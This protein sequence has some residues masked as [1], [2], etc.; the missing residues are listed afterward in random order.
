MQITDFHATYYAYLLTRHT[1]EN[2][3]AALAAT[4]QDSRVDLNPHQIEA[5]LFALRSPYSRGIIE[6]DEVGLGK[7]IVAGIVLAQ[8][9]A[10]EKR[11]I[12]IIVPAN[13]RR[14][15]QIEL[16]EKFYLS[17][18]IM[19]GEVFK[20][21]EKSQSNPFLL[22]DIII[23]SYN[24]AHAKSNF[25]RAVDWDIC[26]IDEAHKLRNVYKPDNVIARS[27]KEALRDCYKIMLTATP[28]QNSLMEL[29]GL[30]SFIDDYTFGD[31]DSFKSQFANMRA[32]NQREF[33][34]LSDRMKSLCTRTLRRQVV[35]Y[36]KYTERLPITQ[37]FSPT[38]AEQELYDK[39]SA[40]LQ[41]SDMK[42]RSLISIILWKL[43]ASST[44]AIAGT[45]EHLINKA[46][47]EFDDG[48]CLSD[49]ET[50]LASTLP[51]A[52]IEELKGYLDLAQSIKTNAKGEA[53]LTALDFGFAKLKA[54]K[55]PQKAVIFTESR[56]TQA[57]LTELL[58]DTKYSFTLFHG[59]LTPKKQAEILDTF[60]DGTQI[61]IATESA[62]EGMNLQFCSMVINYDLPWNPQRI[63]QRIGRCHRYGQKH[64]VVVINFLNR[65][66]LADKRVYELL[67][68]KFQLFEGVF[69]ASDSIL[70]NIDALDF[71]KRIAEIYSQCRTAKEI[72]DSF[73]ELRDSLAPEIDAEMSRV[74]QKL[75][76]NFDEE[77]IRRL[78]INHDDN[79][80]F[81]QKFEY[82]LWA[83]AKHRL[84][85][86]YAEFDDENRT[87]NITAVWK[88]SPFY[89]SKHGYKRLWGEYEMS[90][91]APLDRRYRLKG[92]L[93]Q[94]LI[95]DYMH[96]AW[97]SGSVIFD[98]SNSV[99]K[100]S[101]LES[102]VGK[103]GFLTLYNTEVIYPGR[104]ENHLVFAGYCEDG[105]VLTQ[106][107]TKRLFELAG[108]KEDGYHS[109]PDGVADKL[110][111]LYQTEQS[112]LLAE[113][114]ATNERYFE[115]ETAKLGKWASD[116]K[117]KIERKLRVHDKAIEQINAEL[118]SRRVALPRRIELEE[119]LA[120][121]E[122]KKK[123][124]HMKIFEEQSKVDEQRDALIQQTKNKLACKTRDTHIF[125]IKWR[126]V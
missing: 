41:Q 3:I 67:C 119:Q 125:S 16:A 104:R 49:Y 97:R 31:L 91:T 102:L 21:L 94:T 22:D 64:D 50:E 39:V 79:A 121:I 4:L 68:D 103:E 26:V 120:E 93:A 7:T 110:K 74:K 107:Q 12:L 46:T 13:L 69:G 95:F 85:G 36:I 14:Q 51:S 37:E 56:R 28:L 20:T 8:K 17:S 53:L 66:N 35:E 70:G 100:H 23:T 76:E 40:Y 1:F 86:K 25:I 106:A 54:L 5:A 19:D 105:T 84:D 90:K 83:I 42:N 48:L 72:E 108:E 32:E 27:I 126:V 122:A 111:S 43:L 124:L 18:V 61:L 98:L 11:R 77:V 59:G 30:V 10:E 34:D 55:A 73:A 33:Y 82:M 123:S 117:L 9:W 99:G 52:E 71:E 75:L 44:F 92:A 57:Y 89:N 65:E 58:S 96:N 101:I 88:K 112:R 87:F 63:E 45:L 6:A 116:I 109:H 113:L 29:Y 15:W 81:L 2:S 47:A 80:I 78:K 114:A 60:K 118:R 115:Q 62:A 24:F 38:A